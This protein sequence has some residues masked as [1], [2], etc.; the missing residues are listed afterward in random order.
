MAIAKYGEEKLRADVKAV[1]S[2]LKNSVAI[3]AD[4]DGGDK[5]FL[6]K[7]RLDLIE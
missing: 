5:N 7:T 2:E 4:A 3:A 6:R 1:F